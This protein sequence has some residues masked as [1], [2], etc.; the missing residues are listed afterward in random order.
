MPRPRNAS[1]VRDAMSNAGSH[2][3]DVVFLRLWNATAPRV[4][5]ETIADQHGF[6][7]D[8]LPSGMNAEQAWQRACRTTKV[9]GYLIRQIAKT[10]K[11]ITWGAV[12]EDVDVAQT[13]LD[14]ALETRFALLRANEAIVHEDAQHSVAQAVA[15]EYSV[16]LGCVTTDQIR[17]MVRSVCRDRGG[18]AIG[19]EFF[20]PGAHAT[21]LRAM[22]AVVEDLGKSQLWL[23][24]IHDT[25]D[26]RQT[27]DRAMRAS[28]EDDLTGIANEIDSFDATTRV[29]TMEHRLEK[30]AE[31]R[32]KANLYAGIL[33][34]AHGDL[35]ERINQLQTKVR[36]MIGIR[37]RE[38]QQS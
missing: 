38:A 16:L 20:V 2:L 9:D 19:T 37:D 1:D 25:A 23:L 22:Q 35:N 6:P 7:T 14:Y 30:F 33:E 26:S 32:N 36:G 8:L 3:G 15:N 11:A 4:R 24:P 17:S 34:T 29:G 5:L 10:D 12:R 18:I 13:D 28:L 21:L 27:L 31:L